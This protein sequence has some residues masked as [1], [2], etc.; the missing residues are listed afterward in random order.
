M[1]WKIEVEN[2]NAILAT[3][4]PAKA[5]IKDQPKDQLQY[6]LHPD[7]RLSLSLKPMLAT[8]LTAWSFK[9]KE[10]NDRMWAEDAHTQKL[11]DASSATHALHWSEKKDILS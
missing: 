5:L 7:L 10:C 2:L 4:V 1:D 11:I 9:V 8:D 6:N 3:S